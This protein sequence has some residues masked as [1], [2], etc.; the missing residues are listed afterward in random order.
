MH[1]AST[2]A[3]RL[4]A[5]R[6]LR[7]TEEPVPEPAAGE[8]LLRVLSVGLCG[9]DAH[10]FEE[11][12]IGD[13][14]VGDGLVLGH[15]LSAVIESGPRAGE[16]V[17]IDPA[18]PC[19]VCTSCRAGRFNLCL[20]L[21]FAGH[22]STDGGLRRLMVWP[23]RC[24]VTLPA[25]IPDDSGALLE[26][27]GVA[28]HAI[29]VAPPGPDSSVGVIGVGPIGLLT[30]AALRMRGVR[31]ILVT[32]RLPHRLDMAIKMGADEAVLATEDETGAMTLLSAV[33]DGLDIV[34]E[35]A[36]T[37]SGVESSLRAAR[38]GGKVALVGIPAADR[39]TFPAS[40]ARRRE[41]TLHLVRR[42][43]PGDLERAAKLV[44]SDPMGIEQLVTHRHPLEQTQDAFEALVARV[45]VKV[46]VT[47]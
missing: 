35:T 10:W 5:A 8:V 17:A 43:Q 2:P 13:A 37:D 24:L 7:F 28:L 19:L 42:M 47:P 12:E 11:G 26:P 34:F 44:A 29:D 40:E 21:R 38:P 36:G 46:M 25:E 30:V 32:D 15:E 1:T 22:G 33:G 4:M 16:R 14:G 39:T 6:T 31:N 9:S 3:V 41:L 20:D 18:V 23:E 27:L 45:G